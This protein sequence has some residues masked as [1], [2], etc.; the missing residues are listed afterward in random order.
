MGRN[1]GDGRGASRRLR[2][3][4]GGLTRF[5]VLALTAAIWFL[6]KFLR[7]A[8]P[9]LFEPFQ[10]TYGVSNAEVGA[11]F[12]GFM[13]VYAAMQF[14]S[15]ALADRLGSVRVVVAGAALAA[16]GALAVAVG[17]VAGAAAGF[18]VLVATMLVMGGGTG[19]HKTVAIRLLARVYPART[20]RALGAFDTVGTFGGV[21]APIAV[22]AFTTGLLSGLPGD[23]W[24]WLFFSAGLVGVALAV[25]FLRRVPGRLQAEHAET[26]SAVAESP[27]AES[28]VGESADVDSGDSV[29]DDRSVEEKTGSN[30]ALRRYVR[31]F[32]GR[33]LAAFVVVTLSFSF[34][35]NG[36]VAFLPLYLTREAGLAAATAGGLY[37]LLFLV[38]FVQLFSGEASDRAGQLP[39]IVAALSLATAGVLA[40]VLLPIGG[41]PGGA[42]GVAVAVAVGGIGMHGFRPVRG[43]YLMVVLPD[44]IAGGALGVVRTGLMG[45]G[46]VAPV[47]IGVI[48]DGVG[49]RPAFALL[50]AAM[51]TAATIAVGLWLTAE[52]A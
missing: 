35:Y 21:V 42:L 18:G 9:P 52:R 40:L 33:R 43:S 22:V 11:A 41:T 51:A 44:D 12:T 45:A 28:A 26:E 5:D 34:A 25:A 16:V 47:I 20:G 6:G 14:P 10:G 50:A 24:R 17:S 48:S 4:L 46:A 32:S 30:P 13:L 49:F 3:R 2:D 23:P 15:G 27:A 37:S 36:L 7:Y 19:A 8:F 1:P 39:V 38:S 31:L 29:D